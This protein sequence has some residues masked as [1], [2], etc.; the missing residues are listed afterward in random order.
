MGH[1]NRSQIRVALRERTPKVK[2]S[3]AIVLFEA[4]PSLPL[5]NYKDVE[6]NAFHIAAVLSKLNQ[7]R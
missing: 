5:P 7:Q 1:V 4:A 3:I 2:P 6:A